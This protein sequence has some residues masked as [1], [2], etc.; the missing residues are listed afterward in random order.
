MGE[1]PLEPYNDLADDVVHSVRT[2]EPAARV[3]M[4]EV[5]IGLFCVHCGFEIHPKQKG[6]RC[7]CI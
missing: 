2:M 1:S 5:L 4:V 7:P 3:A 6:D